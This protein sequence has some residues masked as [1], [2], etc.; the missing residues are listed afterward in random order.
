MLTN[1]NL[2]PKHNGEIATGV[3]IPHSAPCG[4]VEI[5]FGN[6]IAN[7]LLDSGSSLSFCDASLK[8]DFV[9]LGSK[10]NDKII[11]VRV[12]DRRWVCCPGFVVAN[13]RMKR[14][15]FQYPLIFMP[16]CLQTVILGVDFMTFSGI[17]PDFQDSKWCWKTKQS[18]W[19]PLRRSPYLPLSN[20][21][22]YPA[23]DEFS[24]SEEDIRAKVESIEILND[25]QKAEL[26]EI[27]LE[28]IWVFSLRPGKIEAEMDIELKDPNAPPVAIKPY[29]LSR[30]K[31]LQ[32]D[33]HVENMAA[34]GII[35]KGHSPFAAP[36][37]IVPKRGG[38]TRMVI[39]YCELNKQIIGDNFPTPNLTDL[40]SRALKPLFKTSLDCR[41]AYWHMPMTKRSASIAAFVTHRDQWIPRR[42]MFGLK[43]A[44]AQ[45]CRAVTEI[46]EPVRHLDVR[47][48]FDDISLL[49]ETWPRH[50]L[51]IR[52]GLKTLGT[53]GLRFNLQKTDFCKKELLVL[54]YLITDQG[55]LPNPAKYKI[56]QDWPLPTTIKQVRKFIGLATWFKK[57]VLNFAHKM[58]PLYEILK[59]KEP[60]FFW[61][62]KQDEA[63]ACIKSDLVTTPVL[64][65][66][67]LSKPWHIF[68]D[69]SGSGIGAILA[70]YDDCGKLRTIDMV[71]RR[72]SNAERRYVTTE[73]EMLAIIFALK[74]WKHLIEG[75]Q[76]TC[77]CDHRPLCLLK[78]LK[79]P[80]G[81]IAKWL[82]DMSMLDAK[83]IFNPG[84]LNQPA[85]ALSRLYEEE[86]AVTKLNP[87]LNQIPSSDP[88]KPLFLFN[89]DCFAAS[90]DVE[91]VTLG[92]IATEL[93]KDPYTCALLKSF[94]E[95]H[96]FLDASQLFKTA[97]LSPQNGELNIDYL[98]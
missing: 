63:F 84:K 13:F 7:A 72:L 4:Y 25:Q 10:V 65:P 32:I 79:D 46:V 73:R 12:A 1:V 38:K 77:Y 75:G 24:A 80:T 69:A 86:S 42:C 53:A 90:V 6:E 17:C 27:L 56:L 82:V 85:D 55:I 61:G 67:D 97:A 64:A 94:T 74:K 29:H 14:R 21:G 50:L 93:I 98:M 5:Y 49:H 41:D 52:E 37:F 96:L 11:R 92:R 88:D 60:K 28:L 40:V 34:Q 51:A 58:A 36:V 71:S 47:S 22:I 70:Q 81:R 15:V 16:N 87:I 83:L 2:D 33:E 31:E 95:N 78:K 19:Y 57:F 39:A 59:G 91:Q 76:I 18:H 43:T 54:G 30:F 45:F 44:P 3:T 66:P 23:L 26:V 89:N 68:S 62:P 48:Y 35:F 9:K 20:L 8:D